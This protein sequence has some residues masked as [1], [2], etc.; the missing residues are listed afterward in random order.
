M[1]SC[2]HNLFPTEKSTNMTSE[3]KVGAVFE[4]KEA[5]QAKLLQLATSTTKDF[6][7]S[8]NR[9]TKYLAVCYSNKTTKGWKED[10]TTC[11]WLVHAKPYCKGSPDGSWIVSDFVS[12]HSCR[13]CDS[14][15][16]RNYSSKV[17]SKAS[18]TVSTF[19]PSK[20][21][22]GATQQLQNMVKASD[23]ITLGK[24]QAHSIVKSKSST[25]THI[26]IGQYLLLKSY[27]DFLCDKDQNGT[28]V[29]ETQP[30]TW[31]SS[32]EQFGRSYVCFS[33]VKEFWSKGGCTPLFVVDGTFTTT[34]IIK[35]TLLFAVSY[36]GNNELV[37]LAYAVCDIEN[38]N[39]WEWF[40][41][42]LINDFPGCSCVLGDYDKGLQSEEVQTVLGNHG[43]LFSRCVR[44][45]QSNCKAS[46]PVGAG[47]NRRYET[48]TMKLAKAR[49]M[50]D[51][52]RHLEA[53]E[54]DIGTEQKEWWLQRKHQFAT[55]CFLAKG[56]KRY[57]KTLSN[58]AEQLNSVHKDSRSEPLLTLLHSLN[59]WNMMK[60]SMRR[61]KAEE[62]VSDNQE[63]TDYASKRHAKS[64]EEG[65]RWN[66]RV[67]NW[68]QDRCEVKANISD[69][70]SPLSS[71]DLCINTSHKKVACQCKWMDE[72]GM[73]C[74][75]ACA[76]MAREQG[77]DLNVSEWYEGRF[78]SV[79]YLDCYRV[80]LPSLAIDR[81]FVVT[82]LIP[83]EHK[84]TGGRP[85]INR[86][87]S[88]AGSKRICRA[89]GAVGH[90]QSTCPKPSTKV[91]WMFYKEEAMNWAKAFT[92]NLLDDH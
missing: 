40:L 7:V 17:I 25:S 30:C 68:S 43:I 67:D 48:L 6:R 26:H 64:L 50:E 51:F 39:N 11:Q 73:L 28:F 22:L 59:D 34:G 1:C 84:V 55:H 86:Y 57:L 31:D 82:D 46:H 35:H 12:H 10:S 44:H 80:S 42:R 76:L 77:I 37:H 13:D 74:F 85:R 56:V 65:S 3:I 62:W 16:K 79:N 21:R 63:L 27:F 61:S 89:C 81:N 8:M 60:F 83:P 5:L 88:S 90:H 18:T 9:S 69:P 72:S 75:H 66:V 23:G 78:L 53:L 41:S 58:A 91:R 15:R 49:R 92:S 19:L 47:N 87:E 52:D 4:S 71:V 54:E 20:K 38:A 45:M 24:T 36:D 32:L 2:S 14:K 29:L 70:V 33:F